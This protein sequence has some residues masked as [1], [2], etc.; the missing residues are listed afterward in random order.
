MLTKP[1]C[2]GAWSRELGL[3]SLVNKL[4]LKNDSNCYDWLLAQLAKR[5]DYSCCEN[6][7]D[8]RRSPRA[9]TLNG[10]IKSGGDRHEKDDRHTLQ[11]RSRYILGWDNRSK[12]QTLRNKNQQ[13]Q[14]VLDGISEQLGTLKEEKST[15][16][17]QQKSCSALTAIRNY[18]DIDWQG[19]S[20]QIDS[21][22]QERRQIEES[23][24]IL[25]ELQNK[26][27]DAQKV[28]SDKE[29]KQQTLLQQQA[30]INAKVT[31]SRKQCEDAAVIVNEIDIAERSQFFPILDQCY[32][33]HF[34][35]DLNLQNI[36][37]R[38]RELRSTLQRDIDADD[39]KRD[40]L[41]SS[42]E[43]QMADY[44]HDNNSET[45][46]VDASIE[47]LEDYRRMLN[48][49]TEDDLP[50]FE[51][52]FK[53]ELN[54][55]TIQSLVHFSTQLD[56]SESNL[57]GKIQRINQSLIH[58]EYNEGSYIQLMAEGIN[59][60]DIRQFRQDLRACLSD[61][62]GEELYD[63]SRFLQVKAIIE[64]FR[65]REGF[66]E[67]DKRWTLKVTDVRNWFGFSAE[68]LWRQDGTRRDYFESSSGKSG[69][70]KEKLAYTV[71]ASA[72]AYQFGLDQSDNI[73]S[74]RFV[75]IDEAFGRGSESSTRYALRLFQ[76]LGLQLLVV[77]PLQKIHVIEP[78]I[79]HV[80]F[81]HIEQGKN[82]QLRN[83]TIEAYREEKQQ[84]EQQKLEATLEGMND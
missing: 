63:E 30:D 16:D 81:V 15:L 68:E 61:T 78:Y 3:H 48:A 51:S 8:F 37:V 36:R 46:E 41:R 2:A 19:S 29:A 40:R 82:S 11:D 73:R 67:I 45:Q 84:R 55:K 33:Q 1:I 77:T 57:K 44:C 34:D 9:I 71:L 42:V 56:R 10:Q 23:S 35:S 70:Q 20:R 58:I 66:A 74:Y 32:R 28:R 60:G 6:L 54:E 14:Q 64:R 4:E 47:A 62:L 18:S 50:R 43:K 17:Q 26:L 59:D 69:G 53:Q 25:R 7:T 52:K 12:L 24:D 5:F 49:L 72:L 22:Q 76:H 75:V 83:M 80:H 39:K 79:N 21:L 65:G 27:V 13:Q 38:E 31:Q